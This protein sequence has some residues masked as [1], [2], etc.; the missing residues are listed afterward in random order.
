[1]DIIIIMNIFINEILLSPF[2]L[3]YRFD[4]HFLH[5]NTDYACV[6]CHFIIYTIFLVCMCVVFQS[7]VGIKLM[8]FLLCVWFFV[9][10]IFCVHILY[11]HEYANTVQMFTYK[12]HAYWAIIIRGH[13]LILLLRTLFMLSKHH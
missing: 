1:M 7:R 6:A 11:R 12:Q 2:A 3:S 13:I 8:V 9:C 4:V 5:F 10:V